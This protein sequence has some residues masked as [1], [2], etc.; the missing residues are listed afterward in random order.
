MTCV[1]I[2]S[3]PDMSSELSTLSTMSSMFS[4]FVIPGNAAVEVPGDD[5]AVPS[6]KLSLAGIGDS[7]DSA[8]SAAIWPSSSAVIVVAVTLAEDDV[9]VTSFWVL[10][11]GDELSNVDV[12]DGCVNIDESCGIP[13]S[14][15]DESA[16]TETSSMLASWS[17]WPVSDGPALSLPEG[18]ALI[19]TGC[20]SAAD[21]APEASP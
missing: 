6:A 10:I 21:W 11:C 12:S 7:V 9:G 5:R 2:V 19:F 18:S 15:E 13:P 14:A 17:E 1:A 20:G 4:F 16:F 8:M 3:F